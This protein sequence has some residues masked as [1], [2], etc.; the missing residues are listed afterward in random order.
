[1]IVD[2]GDCSPGG[3]LLIPGESLVLPGGSL[4][5]SLLPGGSLLLLLLLL[6]FL[7]LL[8]L[9]LHISN[10]FSTSTWG[11]GD[12][13]DKVRGGRVNQIKGEEEV[14]VLSIKEGKVGRRGSVAVER[15]EG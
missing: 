15:K 7:L 5:L 9:L 12:E 1:M 6:L 3:S 2:C 10:P 14:E 11:P 4:F 13:G 8:L